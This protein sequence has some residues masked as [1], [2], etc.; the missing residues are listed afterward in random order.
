[1]RSQGPQFIILGGLRC[2]TTSLHDYLRTH[3]DA[4]PPVKKEPGWLVNLADREQAFIDYGRTFDLCRG[5]KFTWDA[6]PEYLMMPRRVVVARWLYRTW[7]DMKLI[8]LLRDPCKRAVSHFYHAI[9]CDEKIPKD[10]WKAIENDDG[11]IVRLGRY[12]E[13]VRD[14]AEVFPREQILILQSELMFKDPAGIYQKVLDFLGARWAPPSGYRVS[15]AARYHRSIMKAYS[16]ALISKYS[17]SNKQLFQFLGKRW[18]G[19]LG[20]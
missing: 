2:G 18:V 1:M 9:A 19:W 6:T 13:G 15:N 11:R 12:V 3:P 8:I 14:W 4:V 7:P 20:S 17:E 16:E 5:E 10:F